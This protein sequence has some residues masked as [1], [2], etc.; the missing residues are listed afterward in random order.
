MIRVPNDAME[1]VISFVRQND[2]DK[3]F[4]AFNFSA[5]PAAVSFAETLYHGEYTDFVSGERATL[6]ADSRMSIAAWGY[7]VFVQ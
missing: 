6:G 4:A 2:D 7:R 3:V 5:E 1:Q